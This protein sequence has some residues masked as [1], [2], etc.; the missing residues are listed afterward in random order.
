[1]K[2]KTY[3][4]VGTVPKS[5][6]KVVEREKKLTP[7]TLKHIYMTPNTHIHD[8]S[9]PYHTYTS[10]FTSLSHIY[11]TVHFPSSVPVR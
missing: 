2:N 10:P 1:M 5:N 6:R 4:T 11:M 9:L 8:R 7:L 3:H